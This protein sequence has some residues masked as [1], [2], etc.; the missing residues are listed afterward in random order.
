[1]HSLGA[2]LCLQAVTK[3]LFY[4]TTICRDL[5]FAPSAYYCNHS[6]RLP[7]RATD[8][9][10][11]MTNDSCHIKCGYNPYR[12]GAWTSVS[13]LCSNII[14][15]LQFLYFK[16]LFCFILCLQILLLFVRLGSGSAQLSY[17]LHPHLL[18][19]L[20]LSTL[21]PVSRANRRSYSRTTVYTAVLIYYCIIGKGYRISKWP[22]IES[23]YRKFI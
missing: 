11:E 16:F 23:L 17:H 22:I 6:L 12:I 18:S 7:T 5:L 10:R 3:P 1:V 14:I 13:Q 20:F 8:W 19:T 9:Q 15:I 2:V 4:L 21:R